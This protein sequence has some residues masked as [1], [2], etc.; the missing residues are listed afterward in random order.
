MREGMKATRMERGQEETQ[1]FSFAG[2]QPES[3]NRPVLLVGT[4]ACLDK[5]HSSRQSKE[6]VD[7]TTRNP[8]LLFLLFGLF[9]LRAAQRSV[10][11]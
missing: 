4:V 7:I 6:N 11:T 10:W 1:P 8:L 9:L 5:N 3:R 2:P